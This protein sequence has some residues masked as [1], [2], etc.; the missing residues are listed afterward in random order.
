MQS[1]QDTFGDDFRGRVWPLLAPRSR[2]RIE[3]YLQELL[4]FN[5]STNLI[6]RTDPELRA[7]ALM[8]E[9][10][11]AGLGLSGLPGGPWLDLGSGGGFPGVILGCLWPEQSIVLL[12]RRRT[13]AEFLDRV[14]RL[15]RLDACRVV[16]GDGLDEGPGGLRRGSF[17]MA[18][19][20]AVAA[21]SEVVG[22]LGPWLRTD[23]R[24]L[25]YHRPGAR[26]IR[27]VDPGWDLER[28]WQTSEPGDGSTGS[29]AFLFRAATHGRGST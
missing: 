25:L 3:L 11:R 15:L 16:V 8:Q 20:K 19:A 17:S 7:V 5:R 29:A 27:A 13:R 18:T 6:S 26:E 10:V 14:V 21:P 12:E 23:G 22:W 9:C 28:T 24:I 1:L 2:D 4:R